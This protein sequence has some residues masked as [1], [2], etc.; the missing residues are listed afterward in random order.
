MAVKVK[1]HELS[2]STKDACAAK[3]AFPFPLEEKESALKDSAK[4]TID[5]MWQLFNDEI[6]SKDVPDLMEKAFEDVHFV[7]SKQ[8]KERAKINAR[9]LERLVKSEKGVPVMTPAQEVD[10][11][12]G[13]IC[14]T[15]PTYAK[16]YNGVIEV[17]KVHW[18]MPQLT[19]KTAPEKALELYALF[20]YAEHIIRPGHKNHI[21]ASIYYLRKKSDRFDDEAPNFKADFFDTKGD[22]NI[23][24]L[25]AIVE[26]DPDGT[27]PEVLVDK[28]YGPGVVKYLKGIPKE[29]CSKEDCKHCILYQVCNFTKPPLTIKKLPVTRSVNDII[30]SSYQE[31]AINFRKGILRVNAGAGTGKTLSIAMRVCALLSEGVQPEEILLI[32]FTNAGAKEMRD[33]ISLYCEDM[34]LDV[35]TD[36]LMCL[37]F[38]SF[39]ADILKRNFSAVG[40]TAEPKVIDDIERYRI[41]ADLLE[42]HDVEGL[43]YRNFSANMK[44]I[45]G[46]LAI[47]S[48]IF[49]IV[50][51]YGY[52]VYQKDL[53]KEKLGSDVRFCTDKAVEELIKLYDVYDETLR[54][55]NLV[56]YDDQILM[57]FEL[58]AQDPFLLDE[59]GFRHITV[60][61][62]QDSNERNIELLKHLIQAPSFESLM[63]VGDDSQ[64]I[65]SF[66]DTSPKYIID[67]EKYIERDVEDVYLLENHR[68]TPEVIDFANRINE[69]N[70]YRIKKELVPVRPSGK[71]VTVKGFQTGKEELDYVIDGIKAQLEAGRKPEDIAVIAG[72]KYQLAKVADR[73]A[74]ENIESVMLNPELMMDNSRVQALVALANC[75]QNTSD[76]KD[77]LVY[78]NALRDGALKEASCEVIEQ[79]IEG[80]RRSIE[81]LQAIPDEKVAKTRFFEMAREIDH[82][83]DE[84]YDHFLEGLERKPFDK[85]LEYLGD[86][87]EFG[88]GQAYRRIADYP[89]VVLTTAHS[90]KGLEWPV[91]F[92]MIGNFHDEVLDNLGR[93]KEEAIE[94]KRRLLFVLATR[95]RDE[96]YITAPY[97][98]YGKAGN[99]TYNRFLKESYEANGQNF[100]ITEIE[101]EKKMRALDKANAKKKK[102]IEEY[103]RSKK[104][105]KNSESSEKVS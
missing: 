45:K 6:D 30:L 101:N 72:S 79:E 46:A 5:L 9:L 40:F 47:T 43:N 44:E 100:S 94:E 75:S 33:R 93:R 86:F 73:L 29:E 96:L 31:D 16:F 38:N 64:A 23:V 102:E 51:S 66:R 14:Q 74:D 52:S 92:G 67:F 18:S 32:T 103:N 42:N 17:V 35:D 25:D 50:K 95:A 59:Y 63:V 24:S 76:T 1:L 88:T 3:R 54:A 91:C 26:R 84:V 21:R 27:I 99:Y 55:S 82:D 68:C 4:A 2:A 10:L 48:K 81:Q 89:G 41:I 60:D 8:R 49:Q 85:V 69:K 61:E 20:K 7:S 19:G 71:P 83:E 22:G 98:A 58:L 53:V 11:G 15:N 80:V 36:K 37:T 70:M 90:A 12:S 78:A 105:V 104:E 77:M 97:V 87:D 62:F 57:V 13:L 56:E 39:G 65:F 28:T 34:G